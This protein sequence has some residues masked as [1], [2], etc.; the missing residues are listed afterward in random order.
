LP[1]YVKLPYFDC[2]RLG[3]FSAFLGVVP[4][5]VLTSVNSLLAAIFFR[6]LILP[7]F[8]LASLES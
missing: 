5:V 6:L 7:I 4:G 2:S 3:F 8:A 1:I